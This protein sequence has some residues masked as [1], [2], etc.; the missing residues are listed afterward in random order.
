MLW[1]RCLAIALCSYS[2]TSFAGETSILLPLDGATEKAAENIRNGLLAGYYHDLARGHLGSHPPILRFYDTTSEPQL[3]QFVQKISLHS[4]QIIGPLLKEHLAQVVANPP[5]VPVL[6][7]N[8]INELTHD[9]LWQFALAPEEEFEPLSQ[10][11]QQNGIS[12]VTVLSSTDSNSKRLQTGFEKVWQAHGGKLLNSLVLSNNSP[13][14][15]DNAIK[16]L[17]NQTKNNNTQAFYLASPQYAQRV[18]GLLNFYQRNPLPVFSASQAYDAEK[19]TLERQELE[20][21]YFCGLPWVINPE[22]WSLQQKIHQVAEPDSSGYDRLLAFGADAWTISQKLRQ[23]Q[24]FSLEGRTGTLTVNAG[25]IKR[26]PLCAKVI[27][28]KAQ[29]LNPTTGATSR[30]TRL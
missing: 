7:L 5:R 24:T 3:A 11:M 2:C 23:T 4:T 28:G 20:G 25:Q 18:I 14:E 16:Q 12:T 9:S 8:R 22:R 6:A 26:T 27:H 10:L 30:A 17:A 21:L 1:I 29:A 19:S 15:L 13:K